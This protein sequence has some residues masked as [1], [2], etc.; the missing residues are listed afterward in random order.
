MVHVEQPGVLQLLTA[1]DAG[2]EGVPQGV[3]L[4][5]RCVEHVGQVQVLLAGDV[6]QVRF[7]LVHRLRQPQRGQMFLERKKRGIVDDQNRFFFCS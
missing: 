1:E 7:G 5:R 4:Q 6:G 3:Q 2:V